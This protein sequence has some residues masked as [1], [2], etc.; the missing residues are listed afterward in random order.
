MSSTTAR[1][2]MRAAHG[3]TRAGRP[4]PRPGTQACV[5]RGAAHANA[6]PRDR[7]AW[8][9]PG[10]SWT[11]RSRC[12]AA[13]RVPARVP[14]GCPS[15]RRGERVRRARSRRR[16]GTRRRVHE[17]CPAPSGGRDSPTGRGAA[18]GDAGRG[19]ASPLVPRLGGGTW[20][21][22]L[23]RTVRA[24]MRAQNEPTETVVRL[25]RGVV[26]GRPDEEIPGALHVEA[27]DE[28]AVADGTIWPQ[29]RGSRLAALAVGARDEERTL[30]LCA[31]PGGRRACSRARSSPWRSTRPVHVSWWRTCGVS[32]CESAC[33][34]LT[35][36]SCRWS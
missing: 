28:R 19:G 24:C 29:S 26:A 10:P 21:R 14:R 23:G 20:W 25:V 5:R 1:M 34:A 9:A 33:S 6:R 12:A 30:D 15:V 17:C 27:V 32:G 3:F 35:A 18:G 13:R 31:A 11:R 36:E 2:Q 7:D 16:A 4:R 22:D 8:E